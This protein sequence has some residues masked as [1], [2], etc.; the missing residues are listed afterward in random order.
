M[1]R[2]LAEL[3]LSAKGV[4]VVAI[5]VCALL[6]ALAAFLA[7]ERETRHAL[8]WVDHTY[9]VRSELRQAAEQLVD[10]DAA[11][12]GYLLT[13]QEA[14]RARYRNSEL[15]IAPHIARL[16]R[17][18]I[19]NP[20]EMKNLD[21]VDGRVAEWLASLDRLDRDADR[22]EA[23]DRAMDGLRESLSRMLHEESKLLDQRLGEERAAQERLQAAILTGGAMGLLGGIFA[24]LV[25]ARRIGGRIAQLEQEARNVAQGLPMQAEVRGNDEIARLGRTLKK[26]SELIAAQTELLRAAREELEERVE[27]RTAELQTANEELSRVNEVRQAIIGSSPL[28]IWAIDLDGRV[29][30]WGPAAERIFGW[31]EAEVLNQPL[32]VIPPDAANEYAQ[33]L[34]RFRQGEK[35]AAISC[36]RLRK[37]GKLIEVLI[38]T[39]PLRDSSGAING[40]ILI[41]SDI[42]EQRLLEEQ[43]RQSQKLEA[44]GRL[45]GGVAHDFNNLLTVIMGYIELLMAEAR[46]NANLVEYAQQVQYAADRASSLTAQLLAFSRRQI[47]QPK[48]LDLNDVVAHSMKLLD[49]I[50]GEDIEIAMHLDPSLGKIILDP[51]H[52]DQVMM[53]LVVNARDAM[54]SGGK[55]TIETTAVALDDQYT[56]QH[57]GVMPGRYAMLAISDTGIGM[58]AETRNRIFEPFFTTKEVGRGTGLGLSIVYGIVKQAGGDIIVYS[59]EGRGTTFKIYLPLAE[60]REEPPP[61]HTMFPELRGKET[62]LLCEDESDIRKLVETLLSRQGYQLLTAETPARAVELARRDGGPVDLLLTDVVMPGMNGFELAQEVR[63]NRPNLRALFMSGYTDNH[64]SNTWMMSADTPFVQKPFSAVTLLQKVREVLAMPAAAR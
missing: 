4:L 44:V 15:A 32:P 64:A 5:P 54:T 62:I 28:A 18:I 37:G 51:V 27:M 39:A 16:R 23:A 45:A 56:G 25:F 14:F 31:T 36:R 6:A 57:L 48:L 34:Q 58:N 55:L 12:R 38:W 52:I 46:G 53:N 61:A 3:P 10:A 42:S 19:D 22:L 17:L 9:E 20:H 49:R 13:G 1:R 41:D 24:A 26:S 63:K 59:E 2:R 30:F 35:L 8:A 11:M 33:W 40:T 29:T 47:G 21:E 60:P 50:V 43:F 7:F